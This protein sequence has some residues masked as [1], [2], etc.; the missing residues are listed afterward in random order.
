MMC[1]TVAYVSMYTADQQIGRPGDPDAVADF[2]LNALH[3]SSP[4]MQCPASAHDVTVVTHMRISAPNMTGR[5]IRPCSWALFYIL[6]R[7]YKQS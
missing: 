3:S 2:S 7:L 5:A 6:Q 4:L 1:C